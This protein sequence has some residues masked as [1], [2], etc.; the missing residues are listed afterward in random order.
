MSSL[1]AEQLGIAPGEMVT[2]K[3]LEGARHTAIVPVAGVVEDFLGI[4]VYMNLDALHRLTRGNRAIS[5]A[6]LSVNP[7]SRTAHN[8]SLKRLPVVAGVASP[9]QML[10]AFEEQL[11]ESFLISVLFILGFSSVLAVAVIYNGARIA[12][13]ERGRE[14]ASLRVLGFSRREVAV[15]LLG[16]QVLITLVAIPLGWMLGFALAA[17]VATGLQTEAYRIPLIVSPKTFVLAA[18]VTIVAALLS[19]LIVRRRLDRMN[20]IEVLKTRE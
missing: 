15:L 9:A 1:L 20:L 3:V 17:A 12:L 14:L 7:V 2:V 19:G 16:E 4:S 18:L 8:A 6:F 10:K 11:E 5:G 13:S